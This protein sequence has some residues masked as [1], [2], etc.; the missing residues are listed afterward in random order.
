MQ[1]IG[2]QPLFLAVLAHWR[3]NLYT[4][5]ET[6]NIVILRWFFLSQLKLSCGQ[7]YASI[8]LQISHIAFENL[9]LRNRF[10]KPLF[11]WIVLLTSVLQ[12]VMIY[13]YLKITHT[14]VRLLGV[15]KTKVSV[16]FRGGLLFGLRPKYGLN[17]MSFNRQKR[18]KLLN[19]LD[20]FFTCTLNL[21][22]WCW[23][24][25]HMCAS[26]IIS[27]NVRVVINYRW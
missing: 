24:V 14:F 6:Q 27:R 21:Y 15:Q 23:L 4:A 22:M 10:H 17:Y 11:T 3:T 1:Y 2:P 5:F 12:L 9:D 19:I 13:K 18:L 26:Y 25:D 7:T 8:S 20:N 16:F